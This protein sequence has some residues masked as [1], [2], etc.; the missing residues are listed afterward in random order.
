M[1]GG[2]GGGS[3]FHKNVIYYD[4]Q[5]KLKQNITCGWHLFSF[6][7]GKLKKMGIS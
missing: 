5:R 4:L 3:T 6:F 7:R 1:V 2:G